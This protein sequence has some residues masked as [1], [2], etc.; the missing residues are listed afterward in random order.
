MKKIILLL[1]LT[2][3]GCEKEGL[4]TRRS[5]LDI[6]FSNAN[7]I[8]QS[9][10]TPTAGITVQGEVQIYEL[11][12]EMYLNLNN[13]SIS[14]G[15][16]LKIYLSKDNYPTEII[17]LGALESSTIKLL[18][19]GVNLNEYNY[20]LIHCQAFNHLFAYAQLN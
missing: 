17:N 11:N 9:T 7:L 8:Y 4:H 3:F 13:F 10:F 20:V 14:E 5:S 1:I 2:F 15:P 16:D 19:S 18:P 12:N 6:D